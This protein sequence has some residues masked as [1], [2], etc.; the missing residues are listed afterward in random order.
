[1]K[2]LRNTHEVN[3]GADGKAKLVAMAQ[4]GELREGD[5]VRNTSPHPSLKGLE[6]TVIRVSG[7]VAVVQIDG[8]IST[9]FPLSDLVKI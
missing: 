1:M 6:G 4:P 5:R 9:S 8:S 3:Y 2:K 7:S